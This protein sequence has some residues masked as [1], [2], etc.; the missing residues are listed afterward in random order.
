MSKSKIIPAD[1]I[2]RLQG[3]ETPLAF[4]LPTKNSSRYPLMH[5]DEVNNVN[6]PLRYARN[7][8]S[9]F[10][11]E[12][13]GHAILEPIVFEDGFLRVP[14]NNPVLQ[15][16]LH[17]HPMNGKSFVEVN[18]EKDAQAD[19]EILNLEV[20]ALIAAKGLAIE[21]LETISRVLFNKDAS[22]VYSS[23]LKRDVLIFARANPEE[24]LDLLDDPNLVIQGEIQL[25]LDKGLI[26]FRKNKQEVWYN[27]QSNKTRMVV[28][29]YDGDPIHIITSFLKSDEGIDSLKMLQKAIGK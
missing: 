19:V 17:Y 21:Q 16:F 25:F 24:F 29:P 11:E 1:K 28:I 3:R 15:E 4:M 27:T 22:K 12:Q 8:K 6:K 10:E 7:Q 5:Y 20:D 23:E 13:D 14:K 2:Y 9:P 26:G 18:K